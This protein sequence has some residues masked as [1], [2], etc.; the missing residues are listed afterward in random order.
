MASGGAGRTKRGIASIIRA[1]GAACCIGR[2]MLQMPTV[3]MTGRGGL[4]GAAAGMRR[5]RR[6]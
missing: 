1:F 2:S 4:V 5:V 6:L 3:A